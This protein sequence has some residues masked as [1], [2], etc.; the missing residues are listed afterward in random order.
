MSCQIIGNLI[1]YDPVTRKFSETIQALTAK[2]YKCSRMPKMR[3]LLISRRNLASWR[4]LLTT[5][6]STVGE[7]RSASLGLLESTPGT[8]D[9][10]VLRWCTDHMKPQ[11]P[12]TMEEISFCHRVSKPSEPPDDGTPAPPRKLLVKFATRRAKNRVMV[13]RKRLRKR[14]TTYG[15]NGNSP[16]SSPWGPLLEPEEG[17]R[18]VTVKTMVDSTAI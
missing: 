18:G 2:V 17:T 16:G 6:T 4:F 8:T 12:L 9:D 14:P 10:K 7:I 3:K 1:V 15:G 13:E 11:A 5:M